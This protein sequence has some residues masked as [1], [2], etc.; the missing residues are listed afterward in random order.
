M[1]AAEKRREDAGATRTGDGG[2]VARQGC[3]PGVAVL[4][5]C[6]TTPRTAEGGR[7]DSEAADSMTFYLLALLVAVFPDA[8]VVFPEAA[9]SAADSS[10]GFLARRQVA[11]GA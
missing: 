6:Q 11:S 4:R 8:A 7:L 5:P 10:D 3:A 9:F 2:A 1:S